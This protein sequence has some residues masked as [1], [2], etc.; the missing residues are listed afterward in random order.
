MMALPVGETS[1][2]AD[3]DET[4]AYT[5]QVAAQPTEKD[6]PDE[7]QAYTPKH[8]AKPT[9][10]ELPTSEEPASIPAARLHLLLFVS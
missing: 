1:F 3:N 4:Q 7:T 6:L 8:A 5:P 10:K 9:E 2:A